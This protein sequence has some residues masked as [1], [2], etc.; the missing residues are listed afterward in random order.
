MWPRPAG[1]VTSRRLRGR[2]AYRIRSPGRNRRFAERL[3]SIVSL[4]VLVSLSRRS[5]RRR[6]KG[7]DAKS[8]LEQRT[9]SIRSTGLSGRNAEAITADE[10]TWIGEQVHSRATHTGCCASILIRHDV[11][12]PFRDIHETVVISCI[13]RRWLDKSV[14]PQAHV[15]AKFMGK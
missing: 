9:R 2:R 7:G 1:G 15:V 11:P 4:L 13:R 10:N 5:R 8:V 12:N 3:L 14:M 6:S